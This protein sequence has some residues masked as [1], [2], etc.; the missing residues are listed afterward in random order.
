MTDTDEPAESISR[1]KRVPWRRSANVL[2]LL[3]LIAVVLP[4]VIYAVPQVVGA[5]QGYVVLSGSM[6]PVM[7]PGDV[8]IVESVD[9]AQ[10]EEGD[11]ITFGGGGGATPT[12]HRVIG[13]TERDGTLS[14]ETKGDN[15]DDADSARVT[16]GEV[17][18]KVMSVGGHP[19]VIPL[20]GYVIQ[21]AGTQTGF[22]ALFA[23]PLVLFV[24][25]EIW[26]VV[27]SSRSESGSDG[28]ES[29][30]IDSAEGA[31]AAGD[32]SGTPG[33]EVVGTEAT[34]V[35]PDDDAAAGTEDGSGGIT[36]T[37]AELQLGLVALA[38][39]L[40]YS[41]WVAYE[42]TET[43]AFGVAGG[44]GS[45]FLL[46]GGLYLVG[47]DD[48]ASTPSADGSTGEDGGTPDVDVDREMEIVAEGAQPLGRTALDDGPAVD[49][50]PVE[51][52]RGVGHPSGD[53]G[54]PVAVTGG[55]S[56]GGDGDD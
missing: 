13:V 9:P 53:A 35:G 6:E 30:G 4:F 32:P 11:I 10:I 47:G 42:T 8:V 18:G 20:I 54:D 50:G 37:A 46:L 25:N 26:N 16:P 21:F 28:T 45:A 36:F 43:W 39:F 48:D 41:V 19:F 3:V 12:T 55:D 56:A 29:D 1:P 5:S 7:S 23:V 24:A 44:V 40:V 15:N 34:G 22:F 17:Q 14:F 33:S 31:V 2:G 49:S 38:A 27:A 51:F 52:V